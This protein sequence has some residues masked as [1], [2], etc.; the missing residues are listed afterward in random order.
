MCLNTGP[1]SCFSSDL[2]KNHAQHLHFQQFDIAFLVVR[3]LSFV[4]KLSSL[5]VSLADLR[6]SP[7]GGAC[8]PLSGWAPRAAGPF[9]AV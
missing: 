2:L 8:S 3:A 1:V 9:I 7:L 6:G 5:L 4:W